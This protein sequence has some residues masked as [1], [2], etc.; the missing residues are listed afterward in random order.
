MAGPSSG[1]IILISSLIVLAIVGIVVVFV[2]SEGKKKS[3]S[4]AGNKITINNSSSS[5]SVSGG[6][7]STTTS[8]S[9]SGFSSAALKK[10]NSN[11]STLGAEI[12]E[13]DDL[14]SAKSKTGITVSSLAVKSGREILGGV[15]IQGTLSSN[16]ASLF[17]GVTNNQNLMFYNG[18]NS[19]SPFLSVNGSNNVLSFNTNILTLSTTNISEV[20][21]GN[22][23]NPSIVFSGT[24]P[25]VAIDN[26]YTNSERIIPAF[27]QYKSIPS[28]T[29]GDIIQPGSIT[30]VWVF[31]FEI[32]EAPAS[33][34]QEGLMG[35]GLIDST[36]SIT[37][38]FIFQNTENN[39]VRR[40][41]I[42]V[43]NQDTYTILSL[44]GV[45]F[46]GSLECQQIR[47]C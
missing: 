36:G 6:A 37:K 15:N 16:A 12:T 10:L 41:T 30:G 24:T 38:T 7:P 42:Y 27:S 22:N 26:L 11:I 46:P 35:F 43:A 9:G 3:S 21:T 20:Y 13:I 18:L 19:S 17:Y 39:I 45:A 31:H 34:T 5:N 14:L 40:E 32:G 2:I 29:I 25:D 1:E 28:L 44:T 4:S 33:S 8:S 23:S 47:L